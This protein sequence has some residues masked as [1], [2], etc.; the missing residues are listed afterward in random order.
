MSPL[1][2]ECVWINGP[3]PRETTPFKLAWSA[4]VVRLNHFPKSTFIYHQFIHLELEVLG[5]EKKVNLSMPIEDIA[6]FYLHDLHGKRFKL[7]LE[8]VV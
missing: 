3:D 6:G 5:M 1:H 4:R 7:T 8:E 2:E